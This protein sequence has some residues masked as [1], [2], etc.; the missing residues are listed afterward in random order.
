[1]TWDF[2]A[3]STLTGRLDGLVHSNS[4][5]VTGMFWIGINNFNL[6]KYSWMPSVLKYPHKCQSM[7]N[8]AFEI[9]RESNPRGRKPPSHTVCD[10]NHSTNRVYTIGTERSHHIQFQ[11]RGEFAWE[12]L[13][14][15]VV[16]ESKPGMVI[17]TAKSDRRPGQGPA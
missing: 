12:H 11:P 17:R 15:H 6:C 16:Q 4:W 3:T 7:M 10:L 2:F 14:V 13:P 5:K 8:F 1:M 9:W